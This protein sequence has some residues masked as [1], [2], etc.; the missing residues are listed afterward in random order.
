M[1]PIGTKS[2]VSGYPL[3]ATLQNAGIL[4]VLKSSNSS[5]KPG[6]LVLGNCA[7]STYQIIPSSRLNIS[8]YAGGFVL[9][10]NPSDL[11]PK[12]FLGA[13]G[14]SGLTAYSSLYE[15]GK[16]KKG[17]TIF[18]SAASGAVGQ[19]VG[20]LAKREGL[21]VLGSVGSQEKLDYITKELG[22]DAGFNYKVEGVKEGLDRI[23][24]K[25][26]GGGLNMY[27]HTDNHLLH[28]VT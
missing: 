22:F 11:D 15:I 4:K 7:F 20:Q 12:L 17:E 27:V 5:F 25:T 18:I 8:P 23:L 9:L 26:G 16:P 6:D 2:Y 3:G 1:K 21:R 24:E 13:L 10:D 19:I 14:M 28:Y